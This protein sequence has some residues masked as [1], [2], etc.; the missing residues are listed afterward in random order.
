MTETEF[1]DKIV[2]LAH[3]FGWSVAHFRPARTEHGW[4]TPVAYDGK[5]WPDLVLA[6]VD[7]GV[8]YREVK[9]DSGQVSAEQAAWIALLRVAG[10]DAAV[11]RPADWPEIQHT[12]SAGRVIVASTPRKQA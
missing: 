3:T 7:H 11:W 8:M 10:A 6:H 2:D 1:T 4:R 5:G 12:L 9:T